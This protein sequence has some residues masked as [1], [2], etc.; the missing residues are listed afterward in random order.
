MLHNKQI[1]KELE[2][3]RRQNPAKVLKPGDVVVYAEKNPKS[4]LGI[5]LP[6]PNDCVREHRLEWARG[7][8]QVYVKMIPAKGVGVV[9]VR[10]YVSLSNQR[11]HEGGY[12]PIEVILE[13]T[14]DR[15]RLL[16]DVIDRLE[17]IREV[18]LFPELKRVAQA[19]AAARDQ[20][21]KSKKPL[22]A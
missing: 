14:D 1:L 7:I 5:N 13:D 2:T 18:H 11:G 9:K 22:A 12:K 15:Y 10:T 3:I 4:E 6:K 19:I 17:S 16:L 21:P 20:Y 8:I